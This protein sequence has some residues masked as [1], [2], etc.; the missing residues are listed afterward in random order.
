MDKT[1]IIIIVIDED[2]QITSK[3]KSH[4]QLI[5]HRA[6]ITT[7]MRQMRQISSRMHVQEKTQLSRAQVMPVGLL[8]AFKLKKQ[9]LKVKA[10][11]ATLSWTRRR[12]L[13]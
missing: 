10:L 4:C 8:T 3:G 11:P 2:I 6:Q 5:I 1:T 7:K 9:L 12:N 13:E